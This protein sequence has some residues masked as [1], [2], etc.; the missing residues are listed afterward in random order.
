MPGQLARLG[1]GPSAAGSAPGIV[2]ARCN[3][4]GHGTDRGPKHL[5]GGL[6]SAAYEGAQK[7]FCPN[8]VD[9]RYRMTCQCDP[10]H[11][12]QVMDLC[13]AHVAQIGRRMSGVCPPCVMPP[14][15]LELHQRIQ[16]A[17]AG[18]T[19]LMRGRAPREV[20][21]RAVSEADQLG[22]MMNELVVRGIA[23]RC[24][25]TLTEVSLCRS[26]STGSSSPVTCAGS[27]AA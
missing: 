21:Q 25:L 16:A 7:W 5:M 10:P 15:A 9:G 23:H 14:A 13:I 20:V 26:R 8:R 19:L 27:T 3:P 18:V 12:G 1:N 6:Y 24:Q 17:Q 4:F 2:V 11:R 22:E